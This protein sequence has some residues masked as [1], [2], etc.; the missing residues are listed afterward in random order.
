[1]SAGIGNALN[2]VADS[3]E[4]KLAGLARTSAATAYL[5]KGRFAGLDLV[6][7]LERILAD[8]A[9]VS[10]P[11]RA[12]DPVLLRAFIGLARRFGSVACAVI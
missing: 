5:Q 7:A 1:M 4:E 12:V 8:R 2:H 11:V 9:T 10:P 3:P 6:S